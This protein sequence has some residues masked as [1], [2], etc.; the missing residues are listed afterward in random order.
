MRVDD[1][2]VRGEAAAGGRAIATACAIGAV[3]LGLAYLAAAGA[4]AR[5]LAINAGAL[6][7]GLMMLALSRRFAPVGRRWLGGAMIVAA[8]V[9]LA[10]A[11]FGVR[12]DGAARWVVL[13]GLS[14]QPSLI[15]LPAMI[16]SF[17][18][19]RDSLSTV[20]MIAAAV[21]LALQ[22][23]RAMAG[24]LAAG[25][26][27]IAVL[28]RDRLALI[29]LAAGIAAFATACLQAD[30]VPPQP[31]VEQVLYTAFEVHILVGVAVVAGSMLL[32]A[33]AIFGTVRH[34]V[35]RD[36]YLVFGVVWLAAIAAAA[37]GSYPTPL[38]GY[39]GSAILGYLLSVAALAGRRQYG[40]ARARS[41]NA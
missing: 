9:M 26:A 33:P 40:R 28:Q 11:L 36:V 21:A 7:I 8:G 24:M 38:V 25:L 30:I 34:A 35:H 2:L 3:A 10:T 12:V 39:G 32:V 31:Y 14:L 6:A 19:S 13:G 16:L 27:A 1:R 41:A 5:Y 4:P 15:L 22:P 17:A 23:D 37:L 18:R 29:A 20:A